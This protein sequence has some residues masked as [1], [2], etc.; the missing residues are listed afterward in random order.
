MFVYVKSILLKKETT[1]MIVSG[2]KISPFLVFTICDW[3]HV[4]LSFLYPIIHF[5]IIS[6][7]A[8]GTPNIPMM[9]EVMIF[10]PIWN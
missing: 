2:S 10:N 5:K 4:K 3:T 9:I 1:L 8:P 6:R 7:I